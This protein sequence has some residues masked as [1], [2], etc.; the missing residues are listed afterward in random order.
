MVTMK[1]QQ[2]LGLSNP[3]AKAVIR[4]MQSKGL[5]GCEQ[6]QGLPG[7]VS[8]LTLIFFSSKSFSAAKVGPN[9][10][11]SDLRSSIASVFS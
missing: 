6:P 2:S 11:Y 3:P 4:P 9:P 5:D 10:F 1:S 7:S 8:A